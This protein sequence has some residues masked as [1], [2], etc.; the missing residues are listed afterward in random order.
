[1]IHLITT[2]FLTFLI[3]IAIIM[4]KEINPRNLSSLFKT[5]IIILLTMLIS[6]YYNMVITEEKID[7]LKN[8]IK[9]LEVELNDKR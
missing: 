5:I 2:V 3:F 9:E 8:Q 1:M 4:L 6:S 7:G